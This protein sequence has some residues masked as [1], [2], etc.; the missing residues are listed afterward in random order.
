MSRIG[1]LVSRP[2]RTIAALATVLAAAGVAVGSGAL[3]AARSA[4]P[5]DAFATGTLTMSNSSD[6][7]AILLAAMPQRRREPQLASSAGRRDAARIAMPATPNPEADRQHQIIQPCRHPKLIER[8]RSE[9]ETVGEE[10]IRSIIS[11]VPLYGSLDPPLL[12]DTRRIG[13]VAFQTFLSLW[14]DGRTARREELAPYVQMGADRALKGRPL[15]AVL[16]AWRVG[17]AAAFDYAIRSGRGLLNAEDVHDFSVV[18][19]RF[20]DQ[21]CDVV[22]EAYLDRATQMTENPEHAVRRLFGDLLA[23]RFTSGEAIAERAEALDVNLP[24]RPVV[25]VAGPPDDCETTVLAARGLELRK[26]LPN[27]KRP[28]WRLELVGGGRLVFVVSDMDRGRLTRTL[29]ENSLRAASVQAADVASVPETYRLAQR[30]LKLLLTGGVRAPALVTGGEAR[31][32]GSLAGSLKR[33]DADG[34]AWA[35]VLGP[36]LESG[37]RPLTDALTAYFEAGNAVSAAHSLNVH[38]QTVRYRLRRVAELTGRDPQSGWDR[39]V[40]ELALRARAMA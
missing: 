33:A 19:L 32:L 4:N 23:G 36:L 16:R 10:M 14:S 21:I 30:A 28:G 39:F 13:I 2:R 8:L 22:A 12:D 29:R 26:A 25:M 35:E 24:E 17:A 11:E 7:A 1:H 5:G 34:R 40:L 3:F 18:V 9:A 27:P 20:L 15:S 37:N 6:S 31:L 38:P